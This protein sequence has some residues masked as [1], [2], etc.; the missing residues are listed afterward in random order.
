MGILK[1]ISNWTDLKFIL[2]LSRHARLN[3]LSRFVS[4]ETQRRNLSSGGIWTRD[5]HH[6]RN[7]PCPTIEELYSRHHFTSFPEKPS[8]SSACVE[9]RIQPP[10]G[11]AGHPLVRPQP[12]WS[13]VQREGVGVEE[14]VGTRGLSWML[15]GRKDLDEALEWR[16]GDLVVPALLQDQS[17]LGVL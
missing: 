8:L 1:S 3:Y 14:D 9:G 2:F 15:S 13:G 6:W 11:W 12:R 7:Q 4:G 16:L 17:S 10:G 5:L